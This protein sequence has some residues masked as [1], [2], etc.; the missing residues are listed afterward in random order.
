L[1][2]QLGQTIEQYDRL[3]QSAQGVVAG[4]QYTLERL[5]RTASSLQLLTDELRGQPSLL[6][7]A[8]PPQPRRAVEG[9]K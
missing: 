2:Q 8:E 5:D 4:M 1:G 3:A 9:G 6:L 7:F